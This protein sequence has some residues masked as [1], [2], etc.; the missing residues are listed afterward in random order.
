MPV[1][2]I[3]LALGLASLPGLFTASLEILDHISTARS[4]GKDYHLFVTK[5]ETERLR[6]FRWGQAVGLADGGISHEMLQ[7]PAVQRGV[8]ELLQW[9]ICFFEDS[10]VVKRRH[11]IERPTRGITSISFVPGRVSSLGKLGANRETSVV[12]A[13]A[14]NNPRERAEKSQKEASTL[15][16]VKWAISGKA[17]SEKLLQELAWFVDRLQALVPIPGPQQPLQATGP[18]RVEEISE[19]LPLALPVVGGIVY[20]INSS[21]RS[22]MERRRLESSIRRTRMKH[23]R[24]A[25]VGAVA[26]AE[27]KIRAN[28][29]YSQEIPGI[30]HIRYTDMSQ[31]TIGTPSSLLLVVCQAWGHKRLIG[32]F[33]SPDSIMTSLGIYV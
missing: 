28:E 18:S 15:T 2:P 16:K 1:E 32:F 4:Y 14:V 33:F 5:V 7:D 24:R 23:A 17:K 13:T 26:D 10:E 19:V 22:R 25:A 8:Y 27:R 12:V 29:R 3:G 20:L 11:S 21:G 31:K 30:R 9:A 6:L